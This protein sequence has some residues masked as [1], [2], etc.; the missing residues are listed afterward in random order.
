MFMLIGMFVLILCIED[1]PG[2][3]SFIIDSIWLLILLLH[4]D[5]VLTQTARTLL[6][7]CV[8]TSVIYMTLPLA[9]CNRV[10]IMWLLNVK[11]F[12]FFL[13][14]L[15]D[16][17]LLSNSLLDIPR[18]IPL[19][20]NSLP[21]LIPLLSNSLLIL[22][23]PLTIRLLSLLILDIRR[24]PLLSNSLLILD[25][26]RLP[27]LSNSLLI[28]YIRRPIPLLSLL[29]LDVPLPIPLLSKS[30][31]IIDT[32][33]TPLLANNIRLL[34]TKLLNTTLLLLVAKIVLSVKAIF[35]LSWPHTWLPDMWVL[36]LFAFR[37][38][39]IY[40]CDQPDYAEEYFSQIQGTQCRSCLYKGTD[41]GVYRHETTY[42]RDLPRRKRRKK[43]A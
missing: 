28:L 17:P 1:R 19:L 37:R 8:H 9:V 18:P 15:L 36:V 2:S 11:C 31:P 26:R 27:L 25:I 34:P 23:I 6:I 33:L 29:I 40:S 43:T 13:I 22:D 12:K 7:C 14:P 21:I 42:H 20:S 32:P 10:S 38:L 4:Q 39:D 5:S 41:G 3:A 24:L 35:L 16:T 30:L